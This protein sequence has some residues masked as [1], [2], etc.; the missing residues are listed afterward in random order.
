[1][2]AAPLQVVSLF[3]GVGGID[4]GFHRAG[5]ETVL[6]F[7]WVARRLVAVHEEATA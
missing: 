2:S 7:A 1:M 4:L 6:V 5:A 3:S